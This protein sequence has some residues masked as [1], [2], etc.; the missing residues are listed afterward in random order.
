MGVTPMATIETDLKEIFTKLDQRLD[1]METS[2][3]D[4]KVSQAEI[5][6]D[7]KALDEKLTGQ[8]KTLD[9]KATGISK[10]LENQEFTNRGILVAVIIALIGGAAKFFG[11]FPNP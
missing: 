2:L 10:R 1:R 6:G 5:R 8:I 7:I 3:N 11:V 4:L 9:E